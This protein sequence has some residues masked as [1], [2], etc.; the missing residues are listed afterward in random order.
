MFYARKKLADMMKA[1]HNSE[2]ELSA[3]LEE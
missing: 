3:K 1:R 2:Q